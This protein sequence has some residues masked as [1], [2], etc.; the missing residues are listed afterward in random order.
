MASAADDG[1]VYEF[2]SFRLDPVERLLL[3]D[4][5]LVP[6]TPKAFDLLVYLVER[7]GHLVEKQAL[8]SALWPD[9]I[10]EEANLASNVS[11]LRKV[12]D[13]PAGGDSLIQTVPTRGYRFVGAVTK[14]APIAPPAS[15]PSTKHPRRWFSTERVARR[16][17]IAVLSAC[18]LVV[19]AIVA[20][21]LRPTPAVEASPRVVPLSTLRG[22]E[23]QPTFS[24][25]GTEVAFIWSGG[26]EDDDNPWDGRGADIYVRMV[27][28]SEVRR[29]TT[30]HPGGNWH[31]QWSPDGRYI[32]FLHCDME[33]GTGCRL[34]VTSPLGGSDLKVSDLSLA[35]SPIAWS[36]DSRFIAAVRW[37]KRGSNENGIY[38]L[39][40]QGGEPRDIMRP[41]AGATYLAPAFS[42]DG[43]QLAY[44]SC[45]ST[46]GCDVFAVDVDASF[47]PIGASRRLTTESVFL[48]G[49]I[50]WTR[51]GR[52]LLYDNQA[53]PY[54]GYIWRVAADGARP[55][56]RVELAGFGSFAPATVPS[57][58]RLAFQR[59]LFNLDV[60]QATVGQTPRPLLTSSFPEIDPQFSPDGRHI[61]FSSP[62]SGDMHEI[63]VAEADGSGEHQLLHGPN[64][65]QGAPHWSPD[66]RSIAF[67]SLGADAHWHVW[68]IDAE[69][70]QPHQLVV[71]AGD[72]EVPTWSRDGRWIYFWDERTIWRVPVAGGRRQQLTH[73]DAW[74]FSCESADGKNLLYQ[75]GKNLLS[76][77]WGGELMTV[78]LSGG[79]AR[80]VLACV[81]DTAFIVTAR[82]LYYVACE[83]GPNPPVYLLD[84]VSGQSRRLMTLDKFIYG[85]PPWGLAVS[86]D[87][88]SVLYNRFIAKTDDLML[89]ENFR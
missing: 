86:P 17:G 42:P 44:V 23:G 30:S 81:Q 43:H 67:E 54:V 16:A 82:G 61:A 41:P 9:A 40:A 31:P 5:D 24:P 4:G 55:P 25:D 58:D 45:A 76:R 75:T 63:W 83:P 50:A 28:F 84:A 85:Q 88:N 34:H 20:W 77:G 49:N 21:R 18:V 60:Y 72:Q 27:G 33:T 59:S 89:I 3:R 13:N 37:Y 10:V 56:E 53:V 36:P 57:Q 39:P 87:G 35:G 12:L 11:A 15:E 22:W 78:P 51:D 46:G 66:G 26:K 74:T 65:Q 64:R 29:L 62:R 7:H 80:Q 6:L 8:L 14:V 70:G 32:G 52:S 2:G 38:L 69:G 68:I 79:P 19:A 71:D 1:R 73:G 47:T 48:L